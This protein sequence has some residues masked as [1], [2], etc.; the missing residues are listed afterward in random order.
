MGAVWREST[1]GWRT[2]GAVAWEVGDERRETM[3]RLA[4]VIAMVF[5]AG[6]VEGEAVTTGAAERRD[7]TYVVDPDAT[8]EIAAWPEDY[9]TS[10][11]GCWVKL[12][13][14]HDPNLHGPTC[15]GNGNC[16]WEQIVTNCDALIDRVCGF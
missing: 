13:Y 9:E 10:R 1:T 6:C 3:M 2:A 7:V 14:C 5:A 4:S 16:S 8:G 12:L 11:P 15:A